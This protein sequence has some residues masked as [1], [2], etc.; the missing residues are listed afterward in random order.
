M[1]TEEIQQPELPLKAGLVPEKS[2]TFVYTVRDW[3]EY[4]GEALLII[5]RVLLALIATEYISNLREKENTR[6][7]LKNIS[8]EMNEYNLQVLT[9]IDSALVNK[10]L[11]DELISNDEFHLKVI[12]PQGVLYR[13][14]DNEAWTI[15][16]N[17]NVMS[18]VDGETIAMLTKVYEDQGRVMK[19]EDEVA[20]VIFDRASRDPKQVHTT[21][22]LIRDIYHGW[23]VDRTGDLLQKI[24]KTIKKIDQF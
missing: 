21:L 11:Q 19:V 10:K 5:F 2:K 16:K 17:N 23:A 18:K 4:L 20:K 3:K 13:Y 6:D 14:L 22:I 24:D 7:T 8:A 15:A 12:A 9:K 1:E